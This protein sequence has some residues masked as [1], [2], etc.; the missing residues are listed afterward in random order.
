MY[1]ESLATKVKTALQSSQA[2]THESLLSGLSHEE[3]VGMLDTLRQLEKEGVLNRD[4]S[5]R[6]ENGR[7][8]LRY[9]RKG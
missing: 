8:I 6:D 7:M 2:V 3:R 5:L 1:V 4:L 9:V